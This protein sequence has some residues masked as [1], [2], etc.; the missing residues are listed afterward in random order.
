MGIDEYLSTLIFMSVIVSLITALLPDT[1]SDSLRSSVSTLLA[2]SMVCAVVIPLA[3]VVSRAVEETE[4]SFGEITLPEIEGGDLD[5]LYG[6]LQKESERAINEA[7]RAGLAEEL[8]VAHEDVSV[9]SRVSAEDGEVIL[10]SV[11]VYISGR[12]IF[13]DPERIIEFVG[14]YTDA[15]CIVV[16]GREYS[17]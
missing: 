8:E 15:E 6:E 10:H 12:A 7:L 14:R 5:G 3:S 17:E 11:R 9:S 1:L 16:C 4:S 13:C 2:L